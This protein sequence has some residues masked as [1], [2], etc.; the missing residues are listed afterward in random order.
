MSPD[1][2]NVLCKIVKKVGQGGFGTVYKAQS[3]KSKG[4]VAINIVNYI[5]LFLLGSRALLIVME[6]MDGGA[7]ADIIAEYVLT[8]GQ[9]A[10]VCHEVCQGL[11]YFYE[12]GLIHR[13]IKSDNVL[14]GRDGQVKITDFGLCVKMA[15]QRRNI[16]ETIGTLYWMAPEVIKQKPY[17]PKVDMIEG[18][19][20]YLR[21]T[22]FMASFLIAKYGMPAL[23]CPKKLSC[24][25]KAFLAG[26]L[27]MD[28]QSRAADEGA[29]VAR[30]PA[31]ECTGTKHPNAASWKI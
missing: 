4:L 30:V 18:E 26:C 3:T 23:K 20:P 14:L 12:R 19:Q 21:E 27:C 17:G 11:G 7:L 8:E 13:D 25:L 15:E 24:E 2:P 10:T 28:V 9:I 5:E 16:I 31:E 29:A 22:S 1:E 6:Y